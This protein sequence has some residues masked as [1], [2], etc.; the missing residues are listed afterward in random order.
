MK[1]DELQLKRLNRWL[2]KTHRLMSMKHAGRDIQ[3][4]AIDHWKHKP[5]GGCYDGEKET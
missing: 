3:Q 4:A 2:H 5:Y 1:R